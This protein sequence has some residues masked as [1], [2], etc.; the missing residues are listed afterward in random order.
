MIGITARDQ[1]RLEAGLCKYGSELTETTS[2]IEAMLAWT[3]SE[4]RRQNL[5]F[6]GAEVIKK[7]IEEGVTK[8]RCGFMAMT[9]NNIDLK[10]A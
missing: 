7:Q 2:P 10:D 6:I 8:K 1:L 9:D 3:I 4:R 5:D